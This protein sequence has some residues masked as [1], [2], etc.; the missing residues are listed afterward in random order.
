MY[1]INT[2]IL[3]KKESRTFPDIEE[4]TRIADAILTGRLYR[5]INFYTPLEMNA[6][7]IS[8]VLSIIRKIFKRSSLNGINHIYEKVYNYETEGI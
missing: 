6:K 1:E 2:D 5:G 3:S 4:L 8:L 7:M